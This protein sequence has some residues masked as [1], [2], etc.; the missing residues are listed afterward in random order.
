MEW[1]SR[2]RL[3]DAELRRRRVTRGELGRGEDEAEEERCDE[4]SV[5]G[6]FL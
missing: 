2:R 3:G 5:G 4:R 6:A 1:S